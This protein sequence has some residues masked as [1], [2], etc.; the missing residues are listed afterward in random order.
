MGRTKKVGVTGRFG[1]RYG[2]RIKEDVR[3][4]EKLQKQKHECPSCKKKALK[5]VAAGIW[6][7]KRCKTKFAGG[8][9]LPRKE[10]VV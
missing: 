9:Y 3:E 1:A 6:Q 5:R 2:A 4:I 7:C 8:A 10:V